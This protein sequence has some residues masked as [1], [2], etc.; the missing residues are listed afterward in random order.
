MILSFLQL[1]FAIV[2]LGPLAGVFYVLMMVAFVALGATL[3]LL[4]IKAN[5][6]EEF[7]LP[8]IGSLAHQWAWSAS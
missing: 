5:G 4:M 2:G 1:L 8:V 3:I 7:E 6:G